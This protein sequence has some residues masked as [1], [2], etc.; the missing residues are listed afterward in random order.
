MHKTSS[1]DRADKG[2]LSGWGVLPRSQFS[3]ETLPIEGTRRRRGEGDVR[4]ELSMDEEPSILFILVAWW[5]RSVPRDYRPSSDSRA[6]LSGCAKVTLG[7]QLSGS[8]QVL[9]SAASAK[10]ERGVSDVY[11]DYGWCLTQQCTSPAAEA[12][13]FGIP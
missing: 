1:C 8:V 9:W 12:L 10:L 13:A 3:G 6:P 2:S 11:R 5:L 7:E 4:C